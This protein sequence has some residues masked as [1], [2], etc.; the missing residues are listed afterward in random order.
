MTAIGGGG[1]SAGEALCVKLDLAAVEAT[2][3][4]IEGTV[5]CD[6]RDT[7]P[8]RVAG[9]GAAGIEVTG[10]VAGA[11]VEAAA[12]FFMGSEGAGGSALRPVGLDDA[13][14][15]EAAFD[16]LFATALRAGAGGAAFTARTVFAGAALT[17]LAGA[18]GAEAFFADD[19]ADLAAGVFGTTGFKT[20]WAFAAGFFTVAGSFDEL[21]CAFT[22]YPPESRAVLR[23]HDPH[24]QV[25]TGGEPSGLYP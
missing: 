2:D 11:E 7:R 15:T 25:P 16:V 10:V 13:A 12:V 24:C 19:A 3:C 8:P 18:D 20:G 6:R 21:E 4:A 23:P 1:T 14:A 5:N 9:A 17:F 22:G